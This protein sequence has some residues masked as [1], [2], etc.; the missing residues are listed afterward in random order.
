MMQR[1]IKKLL[2][3]KFAFQ[4]YKITEWEN[5]KESLCFFTKASLMTDLLFLV[6][7]LDLCGTI[8]EN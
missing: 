4:N 3:A 6:Q 1:K 2:L 5:M 8:V 7:H